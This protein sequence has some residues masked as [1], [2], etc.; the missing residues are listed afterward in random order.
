MTR[1]SVI[2]E[3]VTVRFDHDHGPLESAV[4]PTLDA[5]DRQTLGREH[6]EVLL[7]LD[8]DVG[9]DVQARLRQRF[10]D[11]RLVPAPAPNYFAEKN[12]GVRAARSATVAFIDA[13]CVPRPDWLARLTAWIE[14]GEADV[15]TGETRYEGATFSARTFSVSDFATVGADRGAATGIMLNNSAFRRDVALRFPLDDR[16]RR[17]GGCYLL[18]HQL[19]AAGGRMRYEREAVVSHG[20]DVAGLGFVRKHFDR[21]FDAV[22]VYRC[23]ETFAL[24]GTR[25]F[26]RLGPV[27]LVLLTGRRVLADWR[28]LVRSRWDIGISAL[29][30]PY[31]AAVMTMT[32]GIELC[33]GMAAL[34]SRR[35]A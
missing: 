8:A 5:L 17:N 9:E 16:I 13:D 19:L 28:R 32:R 33:G 26:R 14:A 27:A 21:G 15:V 3:T 25:L 10:P 18:F 20:L 11:V 29:Q 30:V 2:V 1:I 34:I 22:T 35:K 31:F 7:V 24:R 6:F 23:D 12:A 4:A